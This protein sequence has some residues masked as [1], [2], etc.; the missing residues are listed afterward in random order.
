MWFFKTLHLMHHAAS[1]HTNEAR[2]EFRIAFVVFSGLEA[3]EPPWS[4]IGI[5]IVQTTSHVMNQVGQECLIIHD[6]N[7][8]PFQILQ[9][10]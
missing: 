6:Q 4:L 10:E 8:E 3:D 9:D 5:A 7:I 2:L 1:R